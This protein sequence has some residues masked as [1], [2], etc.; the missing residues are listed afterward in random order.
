[1]KSAFV[2]RYW[3]AIALLAYAAFQLIPWVSSGPITVNARATVT[4]FLAWMAL[5]LVYILIS[6]S[7]RRV[8]NR[9]Y[10]VA[11]IV[12][13]GAGEAVLGLA[14]HFTGGADEFATGTFAEHSHLAGFL[15]MALP[16]A[17]IV[18]LQRL[19]RR[20]L[21]LAISLL[22]STPA[23]LIFLGLVYSYSRMGLAASILSLALLI[24][25]RRQGAP[26]VSWRIAAPVA[27]TALFVILFAP[28]G[29]IDRFGRISSLPGFAHDAHLA[30]WAATTKLIEAH[31]LFGSGLGAYQTAFQPY[32][33][34]ERYKPVHHADNDYLE[35]TAEL[36]IVGL[37]LVVCFIGT[38]FRRAIFAYRLPAHA[39]DQPVALACAAALAALLMHSIVEFQLHV[40]ANALA[41]IWICGLHASCKIPAG[42]ALPC[43][44]DAVEVAA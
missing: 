6:E 17:V 35:L 28:V 37:G 23:I 32:N 13:I 36:G 24:F 4:Q 1:M 15:E 44:E 19:W 7:G 14:Q 18:P 43:V 2:S 40:A 8:E 5:A 16:F 27:A 26:G 3:P 25:C 12:L 20:K 21:T 29:L 10:L 22:L 31:P 42:A 39:A 41:F 38:T 9:W 34:A 11:P 30:R 33:T